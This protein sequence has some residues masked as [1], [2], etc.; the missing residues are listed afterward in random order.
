MVFPGPRGPEGRSS[1]QPDGELLR[2]LRGQLREDG[3]GMEAV[4]HDHA[5]RR[6]AEVMGT[7][8]P[9]FHRAALF[10][11]PPAWRDRMADPYIDI[12]ETQLYGKFARRL[13]DPRSAR[14]VQVDE[15]R[16]PRLARGPLVGA[17]AR[18]RP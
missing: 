6:S 8:A 9:G 12:F 13:R 3:R 10:C 11:D 2:L 14:A 17:L 7:G 4:V 5:L 18:Q 15:P 16:R 1:G